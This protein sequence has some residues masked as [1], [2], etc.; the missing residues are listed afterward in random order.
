MPRRRIARKRGR[1]LWHAAAASTD[2]DG[3]SNSE[4]EIIEAEAQSSSSPRKRPAKMTPFPADATPDEESQW[5]ARIR[6]V[7]PLIN[8]RRAHELV[9]MARGFA[10]SGRGEEIVVSVMQVLSADPTGTG[11]TSKSFAVNAV[12]M[13]GS[14]EESNTGPRLHSDGP[15]TLRNGGKVTELEC[16]C[17]YGEYTFD[18][19]VCCKSGHLFCSTCLARHVETRVFG[20]GNLGA[21][22]K[23]SGKALEILCMSANCG[24]GFS[25][26]CLQRCLDDKVLKKYNELQFKLVVENAC[27]NI[28]KC[29]RCNFMAIPDPNWPPCLFHCPECKFKSC[30]DCG[31]EYHPG[32]RCDQVESKA[33]AGGRCAVEEAMTNAMIRSCPRAT[34]RKKFL[35]ESGCNKMTCPSCGSLGCYVCRA[36]IP[37]NVAYKHFCQ[38]PHCDHKRCGMCPLYADTNADDMKRIRNAAKKTARLQ[39]KNRVLVDVDAMLKNP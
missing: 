13:G 9:Q 20:I 11:I 35:K 31:E 27:D 12:G 8:R 6:E 15:P 38:T 34:C 2:G 24:Q 18:Q 4:V 25:E 3:E 29:P 22:S 19:M 30:V 10:K 33:A 16:K 1:G 39:R 23:E 14:L 7:F 28:A 21:Q 32:I 17:C 26:L 37:A 5:V 36:E